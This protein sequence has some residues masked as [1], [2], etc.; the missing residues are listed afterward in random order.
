MFPFR[1]RLRDLSDRILYV[2]LSSG[3][4]SVFV[5]RAAK[6][7][8][9]GHVS[10]MSVALMEICQTGNSVI[11]INTNNFEKYRLVNKEI[12]FK[13]ILNNAKL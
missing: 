11:I 8:P 2:C 5:V 7:V 1:P 6:H 13:K 3:S 4:L 12:N 9:T 10:R